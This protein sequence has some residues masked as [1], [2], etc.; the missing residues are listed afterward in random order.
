MCVCWLETT[1]KRNKTFGWR[2]NSWKGPNQSCV[3]FSHI[4]TRRQH[5]VGDAL[6]IRSVIGSCFWSE[7]VHTWTQSCGISSPP[8]YP[9]QR[10]NLDNLPD[11]LSPTA[12]L[13]AETFMCFSMLWF[14]SCRLR[15]CSG[16]STVNSNSAAGVVSEEIRMNYTH[17]HTDT[18]THTYWDIYKH[19]HKHTHTHTHTHR[20]M[21][22]GPD[23]K[24]KASS[25]LA[26]FQ[27]HTKI[28]H[29]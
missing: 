6:D 20:E 4:C 28:I 17:T 16:E 2:S 27:T 23:R 8:R 14:P 5:L 7:C 29:M 13:Q 19:T 9:L 11:W 10:M 1:E 26:F 25:E 24:Q 15:G 12:P 18:H 3:V 21:H 22:L